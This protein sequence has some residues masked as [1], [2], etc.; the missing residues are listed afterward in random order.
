M[1]FFWRLEN[2][3]Q[4]FFQYAN[5]TSMQKL[6]CQKITARKK[7]EQ[8]NFVPNNTGLKYSPVT[9]F[10]MFFVASFCYLWASETKGGKCSI[11]LK[12]TEKTKMNKNKNPTERKDKPKKNGLFN[13]WCILWVWKEVWVCHSIANR[14]LEWSLTGGWVIFTYSAPRRAQQELLSPVLT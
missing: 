14:V 13:W 9:L 3:T 12:T 1:I 10:S 8:G 4:D 7:N 6:T 11:S 5:K 2:F